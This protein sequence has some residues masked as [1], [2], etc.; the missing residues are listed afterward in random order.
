ME[1]DLGTSGSDADLVTAERLDL[2]RIDP[3]KIENQVLSAAI[4][5]IKERSTRE[6]HADYYTKHSSHSRYSKGW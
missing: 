3:Q 2:P 5:R 1:S 4:A 6:T